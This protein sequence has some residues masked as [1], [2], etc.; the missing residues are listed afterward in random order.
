VK[1]TQTIRRRIVVTFCA[2]LSVLLLVYSVALIGVAMEAQDA[3]F[4]HQLA[5]ETENILAH[6]EVHGSIPDYL[7]MHMTA[8]RRFEDIPLPVRRHVDEEKWGIYEINAPDIDY[9]ISAV[10]LPSAGERLYLLFNVG[11]VELTDR[12][13]LTVVLVLI[14]IGMSLLLIGRLL[15]NLMANHILKPVSALA[16]RVQSMPLVPNLPP[17]SHDEAS[18]EVSVLAGAIDDLRDRVAAFTEREREFT[19]HASHELRTPATVIKGAVELLK[20]RGAN[21]DTHLREPLAR[22]ERAVADIQG[23]IEMFL[24]LARQEQVGQ[25]VGSCD[26][27]ALVGGIVADHR[28]LL[29]DKPV[30]VQV[31][32]GQAGTIEAPPGLVSIAVANLVRN[33]FQY[34]AAGH[35]VITVLPCTVS[36][37]DTGPGITAFQWNSGIGL[38]IVTRLCERMGWHYTLANTEAGGTRAELVFR[39][40]T[41]LPVLRKCASHGAVSPAAASA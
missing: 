23:L 35:V 31:E 11:D 1:G 12:F 28:E 6:L 29:R 40:K 26:L 30:M 36:I 15:A 32:T 38:K 18:D 34:T 37:V 8:Y 20:E 10:R 17:A 13:E 24:L 7:P 19:S 3:V 41:H 22:I 4:N 5:Q 39:P 33:A 25:D 2:Y 16:Q 9:H 21:N 14:A 27:A